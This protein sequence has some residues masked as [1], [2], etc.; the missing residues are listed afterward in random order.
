MQ[1][2]SKLWA[3]ALSV[4]MAS[5]ASADVV[6]N[7]DANDEGWKVV[8]FGDFGSDNYTVLQ[9]LAPTYNAGGY[10]TSTDPDNGDYT[11]AAPQAFLTAAASATALSYELIHPV[12]ANDWHATDLLL[13]GANGQRLLWRQSPDTLPSAT[14]WT[15]V[16]VSFAPSAEWRLN[17]TSGAAATAADFQAVLGNL[18]GLY[19]HGEFTVGSP[20][21][22]GLDKVRLVSSVPEVSSSVLS[23]VGLL[24]IFGLGRARVRRLAS[25]RS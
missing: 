21:M 1:A 2:Q 9:T 16:S 8:T 24:A 18:S 6:S 19:I 11:F 17:T 14:S 12:G 5:G 22:S 15:P 23:A 20:E 13:T 4:L 25:H 10:I 3:A 7:F